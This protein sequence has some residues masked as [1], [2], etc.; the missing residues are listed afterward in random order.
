MT[1]PFP[2]AG[3]CVTTRPFYPNRCDGDCII[4]PFPSPPRRVQKMKTTHHHRARGL[5]IAAAGAAFA[6]AG[7]AYAQSYPAKTI[8]FNV[9]TSPGGGTDSFAR[10]VV[11]ILTRD[12]IFT[13]PIIVSNRPGGS[14]GIA[15]NYVKGKKG[16]P[17]VVLTM[18]TGSFLAAAVRKELDL[19]IEHFTP[20]ASLALDP[21]V[22]AV[23]AD[24]KFKNIK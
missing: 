18:A 21:Q 2:V 11:D 8:E 6:F 23:A 12:K 3:S 24:S 14:G 16:D 13:Q 9:H 20:V 17:G 19:G 10:G 15:F 4:A 1:L 7:A 22:I 5:L